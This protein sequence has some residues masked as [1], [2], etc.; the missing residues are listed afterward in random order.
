MKWFVLVI[1]AVQALVGVGLLYLVQAIIQAFSPGWLL[2]FSPWFGLLVGLPALA[3]SV[4]FRKVK[5]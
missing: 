2:P 1:G 4:I 3:M 5:L